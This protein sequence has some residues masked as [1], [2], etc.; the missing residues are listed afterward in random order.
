[1]E[2]NQGIYLKNNHDKCSQYMYNYFQK[3][4]TINL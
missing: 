1:M 3:Y 4:I 2:K